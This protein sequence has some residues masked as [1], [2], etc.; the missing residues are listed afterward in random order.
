MRQSTRAAGRPREVRFDGAQSL[1]VAAL[2]TFAL[3]FAPP[4][5]GAAVV[6]HNPLGRILGVVPAVPRLP[7]QLAP[8]KSAPTASP[9]AADPGTGGPMTYGGGP[10][11]G[12]SAHDGENTTV[13]V[14]W[15]PSGYS[16]ASDY[17]SA[18]DGYLDDVAA[19]SGKPT[20]VY[21]TTTQYHGQ[22]GQIAYNAHRA[23]AIVASDAYPSATSCVNPSAQSDLCL[24][25][26][27]I[28]DELTKIVPSSQ[29][30]L[31]HL[32]I[33]AL[34]PHVS[35]CL[36]GTQYAGSEGWCSNVQFCA[37]HSWVAPGTANT[38]GR[39]PPIYAVIPYPGSSCG[40]SAS[41][42]GQRYATT[43]QAAI[44]FVSHEHNE[45]ITDPLAT[46]WF[47][48]SGNENGDK[49]VSS[50]GPT[51]GSGASAYNQQINGHNYLTQEE[52]SN[53]DSGCLQRE[54]TP[55]ASFTTAP[56]PATAGQAV[57]FDASASAEPDGSIASYSWDFG[58][59]ATATGAK[60]A[61][62]Y[63]QADTYSVRLTVTDSGGWQR[64]STSAVTVAPGDRP[65]VASFSFGPPAPVTGQAVAFDGSGSSDPDGTVTSYGWD[66]GDG[67]TGAGAKPSHAYAAAG[68]YSVRLT[69]TDN[70]G[71]TNT[72]AQ[73]VAVS[74]ASARVVSGGGSGG[75]D[76]GV[77][78]PPLSSTDSPLAQ[79]APFAP[80]CCP[81]PAPGLAV[82]TF[83]SGGRAHVSR[84]GVVIVVATCRVLPCRGLL[85]L[86]AATARSPRQTVRGSD[87]LVAQIRFSLRSG[88]TS[89][90][91]LRLNATGR[92]L[93]RARHG[94]MRATLKATI[95]PRL[96]TRPL[97][98]F[99]S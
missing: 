92:R 91:V 90:V 48:S 38:G 5:A 12:T 11:M 72:T 23:P 14:Y 30:D 16:F 75:G 21:A 59:G 42:S 41:A 57:A 98:L 1:I 24:T 63:A 43:S 26:Q 99:A 89:R 97:A 27:Q 49:C 86:V 8:D 66:F 78:G 52:W 61:H 81:S 54:D 85:A 94:S 65:P 74:D 45:A 64:S 88:Q 40:P 28:Q 51:Q 60:P 31:T 73:T 71:S 69:V 62:I 25:D 4:P 44:D 96:L 33:V 55:S 77:A 15:S 37:Y 53:D 83:R 20:N 18:I 46:G 19:D 79:P 3:T 47:D 22:R 32:Y 10:V 2:A 76:H 6:H 82:L 93:L 58:D 36:V 9:F 80:Q 68:S 34:P 39:Q 56:S 84:G 17:T 35:V 70:S 29:A 50:F 95:G 13:M 7:G 67:A 87:P